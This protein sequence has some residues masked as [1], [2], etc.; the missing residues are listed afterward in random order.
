M[1]ESSNLLLIE[2]AR[3]KVQAPPE[4]E[5]FQLECL[6]R[7]ARGIQAYRVVGG[8]AP[9]ITRG[10]NKGRPNWRR[11]DRSQRREAYIGVD[12]HARWVRAWEERT[13]K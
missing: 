7:G 10:K 9:P 1:S 8:V 6:P 11:E 13:G 12:E 3:E 2:H 5:W 4:W